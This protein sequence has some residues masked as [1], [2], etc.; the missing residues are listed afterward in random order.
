[1]EEAD[2]RAAAESMETREPPGERALYVSA[3][4]HG[5]VQEPFRKG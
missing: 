4:Q 2:L 3:S 5:R 1:M